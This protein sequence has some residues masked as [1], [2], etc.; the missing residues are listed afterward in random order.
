MLG[1]IQFIEET[2]MDAPGTHH[3]ETRRDF[4][5][6]A[7][8]GAAALGLENNA[9]ARDEP[10]P[11]AGLPTRALGK[12]GVRVPIICLGGWHIGAVKDENEAVKIMHAAIDEGL[13]FF[14]NAW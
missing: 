11:L 14:D 4:L 1:T 5:G 3:D 8:T 7:L 2:T 10:S 13:T 9:L 12:T 6:A